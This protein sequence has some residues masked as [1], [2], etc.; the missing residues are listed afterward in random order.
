M[1]LFYDFETSGR[2]FLGQIL[3]YAFILT[4]DKYNKVDQFTGKIK[5]SRIQ[6]PDPEAIM[7]TKLDIEDLEKNGDDEWIAAEK[8]YQFLNKITQKYPQVTLAGFNSNRFDLTF[9]RNTL[10]KYGINPYFGGALKNKD[11]LHFAKHTAFTHEDTFLWTESL[12]REDKPYFSFRLEDLAIAY[13]QLTAPQSHDAL[14]D[15]ELT[16]NVVKAIEAKHNV[17][18]V[19]FRPF[20]LTGLKDSQTTHAVFKERVGGTHEADPKHW[21]YHVWMKLLGNRKQ[22]VGFVVLVVG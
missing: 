16:I 19:E 7:I 18:F 9:L 1:Q 12:D 21:Q 6:L 13:E 14:E 22:L 3:T 15:V 11:I 8:L 2:D 20:D 4:D 17:S 10:I 5:L